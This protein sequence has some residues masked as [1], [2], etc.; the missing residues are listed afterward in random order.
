MK[1]PAEFCSECRKVRDPGEQIQDVFKK[2]GDMEI[3]HKYFVR[4]KDSVLYRF[5][6][7]EQGT[8]R[9]ALKKFGKQ[10]NYFV[11]YQELRDQFRGIN[12]NG[13]PFGE[14]EKRYNSGG[15]L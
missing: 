4:N 13:L 15:K 1:D 9:I 8:N 5:S 12:V 2:I 11:T 14:S 6:H 7:I 3:S 10:N